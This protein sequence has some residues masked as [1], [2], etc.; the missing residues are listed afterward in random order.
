MDAMELVDITKGMST[1][2]DG[3]SPVLDEARDVFGKDGL[4]KDSAIEVVPDGAIGTFPHFLQLEFLDSLF[5]RGDRRTFDA[6]FALFDSL[7]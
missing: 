1:N 4:S 6:N 5:I 2:N 7:S 3:L